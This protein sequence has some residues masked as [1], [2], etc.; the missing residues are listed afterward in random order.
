VNVGVDGR[1]LAGPAGRG[2]AHYTSAMLRALGRRFPEDRFHVLVPG[3]DPAPRAD[4][5]ATGT[6]ASGGS[7]GVIVHRHRLP[8]RA[9]FGPAALAGRPRLDRLLGVDLDVVWV[10]APA[11]VAISHGMPFVL[12]VH[13][14]SFELR[15]SDFTAYERV[16][17]RLAR[18]RR[19]AARAARVIADTR[20]T[21][22]DVGARWRLP[23]E[24]VD[25]VHL[26][27]TRPDTIPGEATIE[28][29]RRRH[30][31]GARYLLFVGALEPRKAP[32]VLG[33]AYARARAEGLDAELV[34]AGQG[35]ETSEL[36]E[37]PGVHMLG[38]V[39]QDDLD[40]LYAGALALVMP[41]RLEGFGLPPLE[42]LARGTAPVV[43][44]LPVFAETL[45]PAALRVPV[46]DERAWARALGRIAGD[47]EL[48]GTLVE[49]GEEI[50]AKLTWDRAADATRAILAE[51]AGA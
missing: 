48:R 24:R 17:H 42:A 33:R 1:S 4:A 22:R 50:L 29:V 45:G 27:V 46:D 38:H 37:K 8:S 32:D 44:D 23:P 39:G 25:V 6:P 19:L 9:L 41:S 47:S 13:D 21:A 7:G 43:S 16:W 31:I 49:A 35:R 2:V 26:G 11:P 5:V 28:A 15:P 40:A 36:A 12:T 10:P 3:Q 14:L 51:A 18:P 30:G 34:V 20:A